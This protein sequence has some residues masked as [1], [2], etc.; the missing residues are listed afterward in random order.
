MSKNG[1]TYFTFDN[2]EGK[3]AMQIKSILQIPYIPAYYGKF[4]TLQII[5]DIRIPM[6]DWGRGTKL[7]PI[8][9]Y[10]GKNNPN[11]DNFGN[12]GATQAVTKTPIKEFKLKETSK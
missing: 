9:K 12:G 5:D 8:T 1:D 2:L 6:E 3:S 10:F 11:G 7:E 4:D